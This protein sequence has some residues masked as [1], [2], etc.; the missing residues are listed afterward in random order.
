MKHIIPQTE[1]WTS[2]LIKRKEKAIKIGLLDRSNKLK[3]SNSTVIFPDELDVK[4]LKSVNPNCPLR[5]VQG[6]KKNNGWVKRDD[7]L[8]ES[9]KYITEKYSSIYK[10]E[11]FCEAGYSKKGDK[12][13]ESRQHIIFKDLP[14]LNQKLSE[15]SS[16]MIAQTL[17]WA[18]SRHL[19]GI[20]ADMSDN[21][22]FADSATNRLLFVCDAFDGDSIILTD[23]E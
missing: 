4:L 12:V 7:V 19:L 6:K 17:R 16:E 8:D 15:T 11:L 21:S 5:D 20:V 22:T 9:A 23:V 13:L 2:H 18:R 14:F 10:A 1:S 3:L